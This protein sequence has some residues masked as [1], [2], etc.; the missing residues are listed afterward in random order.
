MLNQKLWNG[1]PR[2]TRPPKRKRASIACIP[3][4][5]HKIRCDGSR[6][7]CETCQRRREAC[8][9]PEEENR[10]P[11][12]IVERGADGGHHVDLS[13]CPGSDNATQHYESVPAI[14]QSQDNE[15]SSVTAMGLISRP[16]SSSP[17]QERGFFGES[18][19]ISFIQSLQETLHPGLDASDSRGLPGDQTSLLQTHK[20]WQRP[21]ISPNLLPPRSLADHLIDCYMS[22]IHT[23]YPFVHKKAFLA[24]YRRLWGVIPSE[25]PAEPNHGLGVGDVTISATTF[26]YSLNMLFALGCQFSDVIKE[27]RESM[28]EAFFHRCKPALD[29]DH[30]ENGDLALAQTFLLMAHYLQGSRTPNRCWYVIGTAC[31]LAQ[32]IGLH[33]TTGDE[34]R[35]FAQIQIRRRV[36]HGCAMLELEI[37]T[38]LGRPVMISNSMTVPLPEAVDDCYLT[39]DSRSCKQPPAT[40]S[41]VE[42]FIATLKMYNLLRKVLSTIYYD[43]RE[44][45][46]EDPAGQKPNERLRQIQWVT[47]IDAELEDLRLH[48]PQT[49]WWDG[50]TSTEQ[51]DDFLREKTLLRARYLYLRI[52]ICRPVLSQLFQ[53]T[54]RPTGAR[55][56]SNTWG[57]LQSGFYE[58]F[59]KDCSA[60]C[61]QFAIDL[62]SLVHETCN[63]ELASVWFY[64]VFY[65]FTAGSIVL[66][67]QI[68]P[69]ILDTMKHDDLEMSWTQCQ[70]TLKYLETYSSVA[71]RCAHGLSAVRLKYIKA[72]EVTSQDLASH[73]QDAVAEPTRDALQDPASQ[74]IDWGPEATLENT[75]AATPFFEDFLCD[76]DIGQ[77]IFDPLWFNIGY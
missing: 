5:A 54:H 37:S 56:D 9:Y 59:A 49:L 19:V 51:S 77:D 34:R 42:W 7:Q 65:V 17:D 40:F 2:P 3:C 73:I 48:F 26:Y 13:R 18:S 35:S 16:L 10:R 15:E 23:L 60:I 25:G 69:P 11:K 58:K 63:T 33:S 36:W 6:P 38:I 31:R 39:G 27:E 53:E 44:N 61:V 70:A 76:F 14:T 22:K 20:A 75:G 50:G 67:A 21:A 74:L 43:G 57:L 47:Q 45:L 64:N 66:L 1:P 55:S 32:A 41:R 52:L 4:R 12:Q 71:E 68:H 46:A 29:V 30:L 24:S 62:I 28:S 72:F 8:L